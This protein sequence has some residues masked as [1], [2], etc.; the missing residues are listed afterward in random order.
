MT[1]VGHA[2]EGGIPKS[3]RPVRR[4]RPK[5]ERQRTGW[6]RGDFRGPSR[7]LRCPADGT[8]PTTNLEVTM[9]M[10]KSLLLGSAAGLVAVAGAQAADLPVKAKPVEYVKGCS[11]YGAGVFYIPGTDNCIKIGGWGRGENAFQTN[12]SDAMFHSGARGPEKPN[13]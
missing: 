8:L 13:P 10:V 7:A 1:K 6:F 5:G 9:K 3:P 2:M 11:I 12:N 4:I